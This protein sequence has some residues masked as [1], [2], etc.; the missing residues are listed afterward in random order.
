MAT[1]EVVGRTTGAPV[2]LPV[3]VADYG[4]DDYLVSMLGDEAQWVRNVRAADG[5]A[6][7]RRGRREAVE[8]HEVPAALRGPILRRY[9]DLA[10]GARA[11]VEVDRR[12]PD[13]E[14]VRVAPDYP[15]F[16]VTRS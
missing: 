11:H 4:G 16:K 9:L 3:V 8:L 1:L 14:F 12:A 13:A 5:H 6:V 2:S 7:L 15:V 10:P